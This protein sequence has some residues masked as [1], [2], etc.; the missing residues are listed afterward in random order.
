MGSRHVWIA[1]VAFC[2]ALGSSAVA[3]DEWHSSDGPEGGYVSGPV[4]CRGEE[5]AATSG[6]VWRR[7]PTGF[8]V[9]VSD[10]LPNL[11]ITSI[12]CDEADGTLYVG[13]AGAGV[14]I[15]TDGGDSWTAFN[16]NLTNLDVNELDLDE[17]TGAL[18]VD[19]A[20]GVFWTNGSGVWIAAEGLPA[21]V[22]DVTAVS[23]APGYTGLALLGTGNGRVFESIDDGKDFS[24]RPGIGQNSQ[25]TAWAVDPRN[26]KHIFA[27]TAIA[28]LLVS[29]D[30]GASYQRV[31][32][33][34]ALFLTI[35]KIEFN[36][37]DPNVVLVAT[38]FGLFISTDGGGSWSRV[39]VDGGLDQY[40]SALSTD[41]K[42]PSTVVF[43]TQGNGMFISFDRAATWKAYNS[44]LF[45]TTIPA[46]AVADGKPI[47]PAYG[48]GLYKFNGSIWVN[49]MLTS[50]FPISIAVTPVTQNPV[51]V[52]T[53]DK[54]VLK[55]TNGATSWTP[56]NVGL[57]GQQPQAV[58]FS[59][60]VT[61]IPA[62]SSSPLLPSIFALA[63]DPSTPSTLYT[64]T[65][66]GA[67]RSTD[68]AGSWQRA[69]TGISNSSVFALAIDPHTPSTLYAGTQGGGVF[70]SINSGAM[71]NPANNGLTNSFVPALAI[72][73]VTP[74]TL[75]A[76]TSGGGVFKSIDGGATWNPANSGVSDMNVSALAID[77]GTP[78]T[79]YAGTGSGVVFKSIDGGAK[80]TPFN[81]GLPNTGVLALAIDVNTST[82]YA[83]TNGRGVFA[84]TLGAVT[85]GS[86]PT[87]TPSPTPTPPIT[88]MLCIGACSGDGQVTIDGLLTLVNIALDRAQ[89]SACPHGIPSGALVNIV[90]ILQAVSNALHGCG[91][92]PPTPLPSPTTTSA[93]TWTAA[94][95]TPTPTPA[96]GCGSN[97]DCPPTFPYCGPDGNCWT[98]PCSDVCSDGKNCCGGPDFP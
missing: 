87:Q 63:I 3:A 18:I 15:S 37:G 32:A 36:P 79:L 21:D 22:T 29:T 41:P 33:L 8:W 70:K 2:V 60:D 74:S 16:Q 98:Q 72:N 26:P 81:T 53:N 85:P 11:D 55:W 49:D 24:E 59:N 35:T 64:G 27:G 86:T 30:G 88:P 38:S 45:A 84:T 73:P 52:G 9:D 96:P 6:G 71:W 47:A 40:I 23:Y 4:F 90:V 12:V 78:T 83:G 10:D 43:G 39:H 69:D 5:F 17:A 80:W 68:G 94:Q 97:A 75:Y 42:H 56:V 19:T 7:D 58:T 92:L 76:A 91:V 13:T 61:A 51:Y 57:P 50:L 28:G 77:P 1:G 48:S 66:S 65:G 46:I 34:S 62:A 25:I 67:F 54:G 82:L 20:G 89:L 44:H 14:F 31:E 95:S 93:P